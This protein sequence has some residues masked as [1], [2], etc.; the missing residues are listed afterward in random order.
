[1]TITVRQLVELG[2]LGLSVCAG[3]RG[4]GRSV[5]WAHVSQLEQPAQWLEGGELLITTSGVGW[6]TAPESQRD[7]VEK[8][9]DRG[10]AG[11][12]VGR[13]QLTTR[14]AA[15]G[16]G[17]RDVPAAIDPTVLGLADTA[18]FP[19]LEIPYDIPFSAITKVV[20]A[21]NVGALRDGLV[22]HLRIL[23]TMRSTT[24]RG[25]SVDEVF[26]R[27][28]NAARCDLY[29]CD[30]EGERLLP[31]IPPPPASLLEHLP[32]KVG[33]SPVFDGGYAVPIVLAGEVTG[34]LLAREKRPGSARL[35]SVQHASTIVA[36][37]LSNAFRGWE[38]ER[39]EGAETLFM[40]L[41]GEVYA[42]AQARRLTKG[43]FDI[44]RRLVLLAVDQ[45]ESLDAA[46]NY[47]LR[48]RGIT[49]QMLRR[50]H[51]FVLCADEEA[52]LELIGSAP[53]VR[54]VGASTPLSVDGPLMV[55]ERQAQWGLGLAR[56]WR[57][58]IVRYSERERL[59]GWLPLEESQ[60]ERIV[61]EILGPIIE[62]DR[63]HDSD[64][65]LSLRT[66]LAQDRRHDRTA[67]ALHIHTHTLAYRL[68]NIER[69]T[70]RKLTRVDDI[71]DLS[72]ALR[73][74]DLLQGFRD[75][76]GR[77]ARRAVDP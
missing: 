9:I 57:E 13:R 27:L 6:P 5:T 17:G 46:L 77:S 4:L 59:S 55:A 23:E 71:V 72:L 28:E 1:M 42:G 7:Y 30:P 29:L 66:L 73:A 62:Y 15:D 16:A 48:S 39:R 22:D 54:H 31:S 67:A 38:V 35:A 53:G 21:S 36:V 68:R 76:H 26:D 34:Y 12:A 41:T 61:A 69:I 52:T 14:D 44:D 18:G 74:E 33:T 40:L 58:R 43:G 2:H 75:D 65:I 63:A 49:H 60:L 64:L 32:L 51:L 37:E 24:E 10:A 45:A 47:R 11:L 56:R 8:L 19:L 25:L 50:Q 70:N 3:E 20:A